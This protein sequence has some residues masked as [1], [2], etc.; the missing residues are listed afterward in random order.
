[1]RRFPR[2]SP[3]GLTRFLY[4]NI[5]LR[6]PTTRQLMACLSALGFASLCFL[7]GAA[8][9]FFSTPHIRFFEQC[10]YGGQGLARAGAFH[11]VSRNIC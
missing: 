9:M 11:N 2:F 8:V 7:F 1:M 6:T 3:A 4:S 5:P 10:I